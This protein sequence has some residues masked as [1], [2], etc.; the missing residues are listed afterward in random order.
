MP[1]P[2]PK[3]KS[4]QQILKAQQQA[5]QQQAQQQQASTIPGG[6]GGIGIGGGNAGSMS[7]VLLPPQ[8]KQ[9]PFTSLGYAGEPR[10]G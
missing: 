9:E 2:R 10:P 6:I 8:L 1:P 3:R 7:P 4:A 5:Q